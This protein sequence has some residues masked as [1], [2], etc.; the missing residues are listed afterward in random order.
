VFPW[1]LTKKYKAQASQYRF[2]T[3]QSWTRILHAWNFQT[4]K[5]D[6]L[7]Y[8]K[9]CTSVFAIGFAQFFN[10]TILKLGKRT[11]QILAG[12]LQE[13]TLFL[14]AP[15][16]LIAVGHSRKRWSDPRSFAILII[17][18]KRK[19]TWTML[20]SLRWFLYKELAFLWKIHRKCNKFRQQSASF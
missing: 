2:P 16:F 15:Q 8:N 10:H 3:Q 5:R 17:Y 19:R 18:G 7:L 14:Q 1:S 20:Y 9:Y 12:F 6:H 13:E 11:R 4:F